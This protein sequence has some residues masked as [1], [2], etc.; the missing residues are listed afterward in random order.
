LFRPKR[1]TTAPKRAQKLGDR[2]L[3]AHAQAKARLVE[4]A[5][6]HPSVPAAGG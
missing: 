6:A 3:A 5:A 2:T 4:G 1:F